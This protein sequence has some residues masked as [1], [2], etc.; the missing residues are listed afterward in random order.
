MPNGNSFRPIAILK[1]IFILTFPLRNILPSLLVQ[2]N[3][4]QSMQK[5]Q[6]FVTLFLQMQTRL[7]QK[8]SSHSVTDID[9]N[10]LNPKEPEWDCQKYYFR[11][12]TSDSYYKSRKC[13]P[14]ELKT[15]LEDREKWDDWYIEN[16]DCWQSRNTETYKR[17]RCETDDSIPRYTNWGGRSFLLNTHPKMIIEMSRNEPQ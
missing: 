15:L 3:K 5:H 12:K 2:I 14:D 8:I 6:E 17:F 1:L 7:I 10:T 4:T 16:Y 11:E 9:K 13:N